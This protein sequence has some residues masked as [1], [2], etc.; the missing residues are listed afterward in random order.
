[1]LTTINGKERRGRYQTSTNVLSR[2]HK[3]RE[4]R[5]PEAELICEEKVGKEEKKNA[6]SRILSKTGISVMTGRLEAWEEIHEALS[7]RRR[8][9]RN[10]RYV[11]IFP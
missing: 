5:K 8:E 3:S 4:T 9:E 2:T 6:S 10:K 11:L 1:L 7:E